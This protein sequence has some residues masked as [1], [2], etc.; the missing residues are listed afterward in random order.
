M[1]YS[2]VCSKSTFITAT[3]QVGFTSHQPAYALKSAGQNVFF[4][5]FNQ[6]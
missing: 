1:L 6:P 2:K 3:W 5:T 4:V